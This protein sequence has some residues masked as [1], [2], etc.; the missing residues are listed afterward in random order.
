M[1]DGRCTMLKISVLRAGYAER[2]QKWWEKSRVFFVRKASGVTL[3]LVYCYAGSQ[4][5]H[6]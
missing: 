4:G 2:E 3:C 5:K 6:I 1:Y